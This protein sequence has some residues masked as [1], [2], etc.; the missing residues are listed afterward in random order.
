MGTHACTR[1]AWHRAAQHPTLGTAGAAPLARSRAAGTAGTAGIPPPCRADPAST[2]EPRLP[3]ARSHPRA[4]ATILYMVWSE[5]GS[6]RSRRDGTAG[7]Y[8]GTATHPPSMP[9]RA[10]HPAGPPA[11]P[12][13]AGTPGDPPIE[14]D[15]TLKGGRGVG[16]P[17]PRLPE[18]ASRVAVIAPDVRAAL[19]AP[20]SLAG[21]CAKVTARG[22][23]APGQLAPLGTSEPGFP[24]TPPPGGPTA[25]TAHHRRVRRGSRRGQP[26]RRPPGEARPAGA[27]RCPRASPLP[28]TSCREGLETREQPSAGDARGSSGTPRLRP[29]QPCRGG[30][31]AVPA[32]A[33]P[34]RGE[35][36]GS[37]QGCGRATP[38]QACD[39]VLTPAMHPAGV[40]HTVQMCRAL[41]R[42]VKHPARV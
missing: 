22:Q 23:D 6:R 12:A 42:H 36:P 7:L 11:A 13:P 32:P 31:A 28:V 35:T 2:A 37:Q 21:G 15:G 40:Q 4:A 18:T 41:H 39:R 9:E 10:E 1:A 30:D 17:L 27:P 19:R 16:R 24:A 8:L 34:R 29:C 33:S 3:S 38:L 14:G 25:G 20:A 5:D 26:P